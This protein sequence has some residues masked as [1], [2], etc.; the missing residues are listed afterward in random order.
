MIETRAQT[1]ISVADT[2]GLQWFQLKPLLKIVHA[3]NLLT[4]CRVGDK[5]YGVVFVSKY[6][7]YFYGIESSFF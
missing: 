1:E 5:I 6:T 3:P 7:I 4:S 2:G